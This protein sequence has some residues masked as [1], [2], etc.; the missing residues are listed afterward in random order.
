MVMTSSIL[1]HSCIPSAEFFFHGKRIVVKSKVNLR[2]LELRKIFISYIDIGASTVQRRR[3][4]KK[5]Y[6]FDCLCERCVGIKV[7]L[8]AS[9]PFNQKLTEV[10]T[11]KQ[12]LVVA[13]EERARGKE[14]DYLRS[15]RY[16]EAF[17][18][19]LD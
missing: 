13:I 7:G 3:K 9:E 1:D 8:M 4:L 17:S 12:S 5:Y 15:I 6:H 14:R 19:Y 11:Q 10:L 16:W 18:V 2:D